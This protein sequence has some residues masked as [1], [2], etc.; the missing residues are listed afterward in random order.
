[1]ELRGR[2]EDGDR[3][4]VGSGAARNKTTR[5]LWQGIRWIILIGIAALLAACMG[6]PPERTVFEDQTDAIGK[7][8]NANQLIEDASE[9]RRWAIDAQSE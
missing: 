2:C 7:A 8:E 1:M 5:A 9:A 3:I 4:V 6:E